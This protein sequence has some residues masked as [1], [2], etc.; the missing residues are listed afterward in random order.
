MATAKRQRAKPPSTP[1]PRAQRAR[2]RTSTRA[3]RRHGAAAAADDSLIAQAARVKAARPELV[4]RARIDPAV[5]C[6]LVLKDEQNGDPVYLADFQAEW[7][8]FFSTHRRGVIWSATDLG[9]TS[10]I[11]VG[12]ALWEIGRNPRIRI[13]VLCEARSL[14]EKIVEAIKNYI[15]T[16]A[17]LAAVF[18]NL[19]RG[20]RW[21]RSA[22]TVARPGNSKDPTVQAVGKGGR[23][24]GSRVDLI[25][26]DDYLSATNTYNEHQRASSY[27]WLKSTIEGRKAPRCR[28]WFIGN[29]WHKRDAMHL[30]AREAGTASRRYPVLDEHGRSR[31]PSRWSLERYHEERINRGPVEAGRSLD[32][33]AADDNTQWFPI[34]DIW[35]ALRLGDGLA[36]S[37]GLAVLPP[38][39]GTITAIDLGV[40]THEAADDTAIVTIIVDPKGRRRILWVESGKWRGSEIIRR[41][42]DHHKRYHSIVWVETNGA[43]EYLEQ[44]LKEQNLT[45]PVRSF[46]T[47]GRNRMH[48]AFG[49]Q[50]IAAG[51]AAGAWQIP[52]H[53]GAQVDPNVEGLAAIKAHHEIKKLLEEMLAFSPDQH[54]GD[55]LQALW[56]ADVGARALGIK[57]ESGTK[58]RGM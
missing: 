58:P 31:W 37:Y 1:A 6:Q 49:I 27:S 10:Q 53:H 50:A 3:R 32:C 5:F 14:A 57:V 40:K 2:A 44:F 47:T 30:Y 19:R 25:I 54:T 41:A 12:R 36:F 38:G 28:L 39:W 35:P 24:L 7:H 16:S 52:N 22:I 20:K 17:E 8:D 43:Q 48:P 51:M 4:R 29:A 9:K 11:S 46:V 34:A 33:I 15:T 26:I 55:R 42:V 13:L 23:I 18:P 45:V 56:I 21:T